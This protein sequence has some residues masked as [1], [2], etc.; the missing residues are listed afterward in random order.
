VRHRDPAARARHEQLGFF[1]GWATVTQQLA[2]RAERAG[3]A[4]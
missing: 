4:R 3:G 2:T 1:D